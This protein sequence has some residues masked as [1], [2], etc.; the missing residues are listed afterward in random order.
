[1]QNYLQLHRGQAINR[2][3]ICDGGFGLI[4][5]YSWRTALCSRKCVD[6]F[7]TRKEND[8]RWLLPIFVERQS[9]AAEMMGFR[10]EEIA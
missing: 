4:R 8:R 9:V 10:N 7:T 1:M 3:A 6:R 5:H 2:C